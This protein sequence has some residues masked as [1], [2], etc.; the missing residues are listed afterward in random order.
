VCGEGEQKKK[1]E[2][3]SKKKINQ[4]LTTL[5]SSSHPQ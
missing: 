1:N 4:T 3:R 5:I 2:K